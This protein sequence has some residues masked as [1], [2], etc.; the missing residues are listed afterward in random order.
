MATPIPLPPRPASPHRPMTNARPDLESTPMTKPRAH[1]DSMR[2]T[3]MAREVCKD[4]LKGRC[5]RDPCRYIHPPPDET[6]GPAVTAEKAFEK[7]HI[8]EHSSNLP[9]ETP[10]TRPLH[11]LPHAP[12]TVNMPTVGAPEN[13]GTLYQP[14]A[15][16]T[17]PVPR[18]DGPM[19][20]LKGREVQ[21][22]IA[23]LKGQCRYGDRCHRLHITLQH[24]LEAG[25]H[26]LSP[27]LMAQNNRGP[28]IRPAENNRMPMGPPPRMGGPGLDPQN[29]PV[30]PPQGP[31][32][33][34]DPAVAHHDGIHKV[35]D[36]K[37]ELVQ[38]APPRPGVPVAVNLPPQYGGQRQDHPF[39]QRLP[40]PHVAQN[41]HSSPYPVWPPPA[42]HTRSDSNVTASSSEPES[43]L[44]V[45]SL[46]RQ[47]K[48]TDSAPSSPEASN[49]R[50]L[51]AD[52][53]R[54]LMPLAPRGV[55]FQWVHG[56]CQRLVCK[57]RH[58]GFDRQLVVSPQQDSAKVAE[59][60]I[61]GGQSDVSASTAKASSVEAGRA[62]SQPRKR[63]E[64]A[65]RPSVA[66]EAVS[67]TSSPSRP[68]QHTPLHSLPV[69][70]KPRRVAPPR[71]PPMTISV[72]EQAR[73]T[74][75]PGF[76]IQ[77]IKTAFDTL[78]VKITDVPVDLPR[79][80]VEHFLKPFGTVIEVR[81][82]NDAYEGRQSIGVK[83][84]NPTEA[85]AAVE[86]LDN[87]EIW[88]GRIRVRLSLGRTAEARVMCD[89]DVHVM[90]QAP[91]R[92]AYAGYMTK[93]AAEKAVERMD[94][95]MMTSS[96]KKTTYFITASLHKGEPCLGPFNVRFWGLPLAAEKEKSIVDKFG[97]NT[98]YMWKTPPFRPQKKFGM[99]TVESI[100]KQIGKLSSPMFVSP[101]PYKD[102]MVHAWVRYE[103]PDIAKTACELNGLP[104]ERMKQEKIY[105]QRIHTVTQSVPWDVYNIIGGGISQLRLDTWK[106]S[107]ETN[108]VV[109]KEED[110]GVVIVKLVSNDK[111]TLVRVKS[112]LNLLIHG[113]LLQVDG[114]QVWDGF[115][116]LP[117]TMDLVRD[118]ERWNSVLI[119][120]DR[121]RRTVRI[122]GHPNNCRLVRTNI[123]DKLVGFR[124][125]K[126]STID[127][128]GRM[129]G[130]FMNSDLKA[131]QN[132]HGP[133][134]VWLDLT[135]HVI[136]VRESPDK[137]NIYEVVE[138]AV[139]KAQQRHPSE[140]AADPCPVCFENP[141][142]PVVLGCSHIFC[143]ACLARYLQSA[144]DTRRF[145]LTCL[146]AEGTCGAP[147][148]L[149][150]AR[151]VLPPGDFHALA[152]AAFHAHVQAHPDDFHYCPTPD[153]EQVYRP[154]PRDTV[155]AC[156]DCLTAIC[157]HCV[158]EYHEG[159][160]CLDREIGIDGGV[161]A[162]AASHDAKRCPKCKTMIERAEGCNHV[163]C[164]RCHTHMCFVCLDTFPKGEGIYDHMRQEHGSIGL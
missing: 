145:P 37:R 94:G 64:A 42:D 46:D 32:G 149:Y 56:R 62:P 120:V 47:T 105:V 129:I 113:E 16:L 18:S 9:E 75:G 118:Q 60:H 66:K 142:Q 103:T 30:L 121:V 110:K 92:G 22:C 83:M 140:R 45:S 76:D 24:L 28:I 112:K 39:S 25:G 58:S 5:K 14:T 164:T 104:Q 124:G 43:R 159:V 152:R 12:A 137:P 102:G 21:I 6:L 10:F 82:N 57:Y 131:L 74:F 132:A 67:G 27:S 87:V 100:L 107:R 151:D 163:T 93:E 122:I 44:S 119:R 81:R 38:L 3:P 29:R 154:G 65:A 72:L 138:K 95:L 150:T 51:K 116:T 108:I 50:S 77:H 97:E 33:V 148:S 158:C 79:E 2:A 73:V 143:K 98:G 99:E 84:S 146:G 101:P 155:L 153:C 133:E 96:R 109:R 13:I 114:K 86:S 31:M 88:G 55:C 130:L 70:N 19:F 111:K 126:V 61:S 123:L 106:T 139:R 53:S 141:T 160:T 127:L 162:W 7:V 161:E 48:T 85:S 11:I 136:C 128:S 78:F 125:R 89:A 17:H 91:L 20:Q 49:V 4:F 26:G 115:F 15:V 63:P 80:K 35:F 71:L 59:S 1:P 69:H 41:V 134:N 34:I 40:R 117:S 135:Q 52:A 144:I 147:V 157:P 23:F 54:P 90:W 8:V 68:Q 156:P 36:E